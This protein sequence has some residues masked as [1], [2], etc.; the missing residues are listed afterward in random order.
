MIVKDQDE[1]FE[2][3]PKSKE[4]QR[5]Q[6]TLFRE[7]QTIIENCL[8]G[9]DINP[10]SVKICRLRLWVELLKN[11]YYQAK[12]T[13]VSLS[14]GTV[15]IRELETLPNIDINIKCGNSL[16]SRFALDADLKKALKSVKWKISDYKAFVKEYKHA[17]NKEE[18]RGLETLIEQIK[19]DFKSEINKN[20]PKVRRLQRLN[21]ELW[22]KYESGDLFERKLSAA[23]KRD[24]KK[25]LADIEKLTNEIEEIKSNKVYENAFEWRFMFPEV[26]NDNGEFDG[27]DTIIGNPPYIR[28]E[29]LQEFKGYFK[30]RFATFAG[31]ADLFVYFIEHGLNLLKNEGHFIYIVPNK[32][33][34]AGY[35]KAL[36]EH[37]IQKR[38]LN[39]LDFGDLPVFE[40]ATTYPCIIS[41]QES[42]QPNEMFDASNIHTLD[43]DFGLDGYVQQRRI[44]VL[45]N[46]LQAGG[47][48]LSDAKEQKLLAKLK[49]HSVS[50]GEYIDGKIYR[51]VLTGL[52]EAFVI[53]EDTRTRLIEQDP[54][55]EQIIKPFLAGRDI[56]R[57]KKPKSHYYLILFRSGDTRNWF[58]EKDENGGWISLNEQIA[59]TRLNEE[60]PALCNHLKKFKSKAR[61]RYDQ[62]HYWWELRACDYYEEFEKEKIAWPETSSDNQFTMVIEGDYLNKTCFFIPKSDCFLLGLL[63]S[64][65]AKFYFDSIVSKM[66]GGYFSMSKAYVETIPISKQDQSLIEQIDS[67]TQSFLGSSNIEALAEIDTLI[68]KLYN[69][70]ESEIKTLEE[71]VK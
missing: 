41:I 70:T 67:A 30:S 17:T 48:T 38:I 28:Q 68:Y 34:R 7:K 50:L 51:G 5:I 2:Y 11:A 16:I 10:N 18:K 35:G 26:L 33:M 9:V 23:E 52:N 15:L 44:N 53:D 14:S 19:G 66:R 46:E 43:F 21:A 58:G 61:E 29:E 49:E 25:L 31:T 69:L 65:L 54:K 39:I 13:K 59:W 12:E 56:K 45:Q 57:Y 20:D 71:S 24:K 62:G 60:Y 3:N 55:S 64:K 32:W 4:S 37:L 27:F 63:N 36:R 8:F 47:W 22:T 1:L 42:Q 40:E 6:E